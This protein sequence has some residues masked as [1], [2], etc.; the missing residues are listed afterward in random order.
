[1]E[2]LTR[3]PEKYRL[4]L[5]LCGLEGVTHAEA[6]RRLGWPKGTVAGRVSRAPGVPRGRPPRPRGVAPLP[7]AAPPP[8]RGGAAAT[9]PP[10]LAA[11]VRAAVAAGTSAAVVPSP[12]AALVHGVL[13]KMILARLCTATTLVAALALTLGVAGAIRHAM[14]SPGILPGNAARG[15]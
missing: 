7:G 2:E 12:V 6:G 4:P 1:D 8:A 9:V 11:S 5:L 14:S 13:R 3:L 15:R 10:L